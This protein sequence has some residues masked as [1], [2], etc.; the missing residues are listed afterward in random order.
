MPLVHKTINVLWYDIY[1]EGMQPLEAANVTVIEEIT[2]PT[3]K[4]Y[5]WSFVG[6][7]S[8]SRILINR[9]DIALE[10]LSDL[11]RKEKT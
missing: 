11:T 2:T 4:N 5:V 6:E 3:K 10:N 7:A 8:Y 9:C 1:A